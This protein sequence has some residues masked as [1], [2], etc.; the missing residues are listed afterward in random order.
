[1]KTNQISLKNLISIVKGIAATFGN[2]CEVVLHDTR[3]LENSVIAIE[4][5]HLTGRKIGSP[6]TDLDLFFIK[7]KLFSE[8]DFVP[9][10]QTKTKDG[11]KLKS[12][13]I[14]IK[15]DSGKI[16]G[17]LCIN[18]SIG[19]LDEVKRK[20]D[21]ICE[22]TTNIDYM[23]GI[24]NNVEENFIQ[25]LD[26]LI[27]TVFENSIKKI[28]KRIELMEKE[29]KIKL[30]AEL[31]KKGVFMVK[32]AIDKIAYKLGV[33]KPTVYSYLAEIKGNEDI[34]VIE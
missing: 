27:D 4:N 9:N 30:L 24:E 17:L 12:T 20:I 28:G 6:M 33:S 13:T 3:D 8:K 14:F 7:S 11:K 26:E 18:Y 34:K 1:M 21:K 2:D 5:G 23:N 15:N 22:I 32:G 19:E 31:Q 16:I 25:S 29:D 10:Y